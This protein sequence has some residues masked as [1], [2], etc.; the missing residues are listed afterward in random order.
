MFL[1]VPAAGGG[2]PGGEPHG[3]EQPDPEEA[4]GLDLRPQGPAQDPGRP[5]RLLPRCVCVLSSRHGAVF[6]SFTHA[7]LRWYSPCK[8]IL[9]KV[10][11]KVGFIFN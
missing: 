5:R 6:S 4:A 7:S 1:C 10:G 2:G 9:A 11:V 8:H 3:G